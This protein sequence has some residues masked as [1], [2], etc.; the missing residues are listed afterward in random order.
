MRIYLAGPEV[1][2]DNAAAVGAAKKAICARHG[3]TGLFPLDTALSVDGLEPRQ[4]GRAI[5]AANLRLIR[6]AD[7]MIA[8]LT[9]FRGPSADVGTAFEMGVMAA[10][11]RPVLAY[12]NSAKSF[13]HRVADH[14]AGRTHRRADGLLADPQGM[15]IEEFDMV[16]NLMLHG[17]LPEGDLFL[18][19]AAPG[20]ELVDLTAFE[21]AVRAAA[22]LIGRS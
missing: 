14:V 2:L 15:A 11:G 3:L 9:P 1:F 5:Y 4:R 19:A 12:S 8:N 7:A 17:A 21:D 20:A 18:H 10:L 22:R 13:A 16:D 6:S